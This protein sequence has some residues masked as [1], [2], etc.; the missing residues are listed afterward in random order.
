MNNKKEKKVFCFD[1]D[2]TICTTKDGDYSKSKPKPK[3][4]KFIN[5]LY[6]RGHIIF[7]YTSRFNR[8]YNY[9][10]IKINKVGLEFTKKQ[11]IGWGVSFHE[12]IMMKPDYD[13]II[14]DKYPGYQD[15]SWMSYIK[16][17]YLS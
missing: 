10:K 1:I 4:I 11:L 15:I 17:K 7:F 8:I 3:V 6:D 5:Q 12:I 14:D 16:S 2:D 13:Y 9:N